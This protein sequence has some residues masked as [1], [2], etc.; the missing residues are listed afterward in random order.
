M[1]RIFSL[2]LIFTLHLSTLSTTASAD[3]RLFHIARSLNPNWVCYDAR[4]KNG[5]LNMD[6]PVHVYWHNNSD[7]PGHENELSYFQRKMAYGVKVLNRGNQEAEVRL[8]A[9]QEAQLADMQAQRQM[10]GAV[11]NQ[12]QAVHTEGNLRA[13]EAEESSQCRL[14]PTIGHRCK[15]RLQAGGEDIQQI[16]SYL[17]CKVLVFNII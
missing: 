13:A 15:R 14:F 6:D 10:G 3:E 17:F 9:L 11:H 7:N 8:T 5:K 12:R 1:K 16:V 2:I 4:V